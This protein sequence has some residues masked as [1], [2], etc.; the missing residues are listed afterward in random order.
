M[1]GYPLTERY[2]HE[3]IHTPCEPPGYTPL[4][5]VR[6]PMDLS[7]YSRLYFRALLSSWLFFLYA[8]YYLSRTDSEYKGENFN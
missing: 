5:V 6:Y 7:A 2:G 4:F 8:L 3:R 1:L